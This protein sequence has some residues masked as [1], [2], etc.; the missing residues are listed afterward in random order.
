MIKQIDGYICDQEITSHFILNSINSIKDRLSCLTD[1]LKI[2]GTSHPYYGTQIYG[3]RSPLPDHIDNTGH[4]LIMPIYISTGSE[5]IICAESACDLKVG[6]LYVLDD[7]KPHRTEGN[8][9]VIALFMGSYKAKTLGD[10]LYEAV[11]GSF[12]EYLA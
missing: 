1:G 10:E 2:V 3:W 12:R 4:V 9:D 8:G 5:R 7:R 11:F 6:H